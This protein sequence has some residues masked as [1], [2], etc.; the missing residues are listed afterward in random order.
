MKDDLERFQEDSNT[1]L[2]LLKNFLEKNLDEIS[3]SIMTKKQIQIFENNTKLY[4]FIWSKIN[5]FEVQNELIHSNLLAIY[6]YYL[7]TELNLNKILFCSI[8]TT[9]E[10]IKGIVQKRKII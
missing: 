10:E 3:K 6:L 8:T 5:Y 2:D 1:K 4:H 9:K 7:K